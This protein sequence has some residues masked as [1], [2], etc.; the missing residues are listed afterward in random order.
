VR[1]VEADVHGFLRGR[2][3]R[4][5]TSSYHAAGRHFFS[6]GCHLPFHSSERALRNSSHF[7]GRRVSGNGTGATGT[8]YPT[9][10]TAFTSPSERI[11]PIRTGSQVCRFAGSI[12]TF[13]RGPSNSSPRTAES[14]AVGSGLPAAV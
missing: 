8:S 14:T 5:V 3:R 4:P 6:G 9:P 1:V 10:A 12:F 2:M 7:S 11:L 13:A